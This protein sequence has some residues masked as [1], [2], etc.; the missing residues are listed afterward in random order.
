[1]LTKYSFSPALSITTG[2]DLSVMFLDT[3][4]R[5]KIHNRWAAAR[6]N[7]Q[8]DMCAQRR[9]RSTWLISVFAERKCRFVGFVLRRLRMHYYY[10]CYY[11][12]YYYMYSDQTGWMPRL[13]LSLC[14]A[15]MSF[16][17]FCRAVAQD[18]L[19]LLLLKSNASIIAIS[20]VQNC[21][22]P[23][24][25]YRTTNDSTRFTHMPTFCHGSQRSF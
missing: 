1:M 15:Q 18:A 2:N 16:C 6:Q 3:V 4:L 24:R 7:Q 23:S 14:W 9:L 5:Q 13:I 17:W 12:Y 22:G 21:P 25:P 19:L 11:Y 8:N 20:T 10:Y